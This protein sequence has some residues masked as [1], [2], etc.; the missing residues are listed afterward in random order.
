[1][2]ILRLPAGVLDGLLRSRHPVQNEAVVLAL[3]LRVHPV[4]RIE[5]TLGQ[6]AERWLAADLGR[7]VRYIE[8]RDG[9]DTGL[10]IQQPLPDMIDAGSNRCDQAKACDD[11]ASHL[12]FNLE[13]LLMPAAA[14]PGGVATAVPI[15][16]APE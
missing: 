6:L 1:M 9:R 14:T 5:P 7:Q 4:G 16:R 12:H 11:D 10:P 13:S 3:I 2:L 15:R 8:L